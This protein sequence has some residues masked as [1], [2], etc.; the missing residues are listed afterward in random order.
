MKRK[1]KVVRL[2]M[3][4]EGGGAKKKG[5]RKKGEGRSE[6]DRDVG[7]VKGEGGKVID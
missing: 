2:H 3:V 1:T 6:G 5:S 7:S 4:E